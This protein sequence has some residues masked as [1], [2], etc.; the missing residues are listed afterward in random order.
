MNKLTLKI[1]AIGYGGLK[2]VVLLWRSWLLVI[3][4][5]NHDLIITITVGVE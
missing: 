1:N 5:G 2:R 3:L 4:F